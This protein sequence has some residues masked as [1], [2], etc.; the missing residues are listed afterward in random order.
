MA[1]V[2]MIT[3][4]SCLFIQAVIHSSFW[5]SVCN[6]PGW[7]NLCEVGFPSVLA[8]GGACLPAQSYGAFVHSGAKMA[9]W[10]LP[11]VR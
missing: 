9:P 11:E 2:F 3:H 6:L 10:S 8:Q 5:L 4:V 7:I 1:S